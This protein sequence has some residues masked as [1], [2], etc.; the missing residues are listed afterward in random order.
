MPS[1][2]TA[3][4][5]AGA[6]PAGWTL[7][8]EKSHDMRNLYWLSDG[9]WMAKLPVID[10]DT[11]RIIDYKRPKSPDLET[12]IER[13]DAY[14]AARAKG[15]SHQELKGRQ[16]KGLTLA[17]WIKIYLANV[18]NAKADSTMDGYGYALAHIAADLG[19]I[20]LKDLRQSRIE[21]WRD[22]EKREGTLSYAQI[23]LTI[24][25]LKTCL[26]AATQGA[27]QV[28]TGIFASPAA[29]VQPIKGA[30]EHNPLADYVTDPSET[31]RLV[32]AVGEHYLAALPRVATDLGLRRSEI[33]ALRWCDINLDTGLVTISWHTV[34]TGAG[35]AR[36]TVFEPGSKASAGKQ[37][38][39]LSKQ[40]LAAVREAKDRLAFF[41]RSQGKKWR[42]GQA[43][44]VCYVLPGGKRAAYVIPANP[45]APE[46]LVFPM[47][48]GDVY[49][50]GALAGWFKVICKRAGITTKT[51][52]S[53]R[54]DCA[55]F[56]LMAGVPLTVVAKHMRHANPSITA[57]TYAHLVSSQER[58]AA[59]TMSA[60][61][62]RAASAAAVA[63]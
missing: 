49:E 19:H 41:A 18:G 45:V 29:D 24:K 26:K 20:P 9:R 62:D 44:E 17:Q 2:A 54:H 28:E 57:T 11:G 14:F 35:D 1:K 58:L 38:V 22:D 27:R 25:R 53:L 46:A 33:S 7:K 3:S 12:A 31:E 51:L 42:A 52:H 36:K 21:Q 63:V 8:D 61:W 5:F 56:L 55:T 6:R 15:Q 50:G 30:A 13:R 60:I 37:S 39:Q 23:N 34:T 4:S 48:D 16:A 43:S 10:P 32:H 40:G 59:D 47:R